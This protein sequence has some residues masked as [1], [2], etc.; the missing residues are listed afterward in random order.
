MAKG[1][2]GTTYSTLNDPRFPVRSQCAAAL[3]PLHFSCSSALWAARVVRV[4]LAFACEAV[5]CIVQC[6]VCSCVCLVCLHAGRRVLQ[7]LLS[8]H[9]AAV[10]RCGLRGL[11][12]WPFALAVRG[13]SCLWPTRLAQPSPRLTAPSTLLPLTSLSLPH[14]CLAPLPLTGWPTGSQATE[15]G[16]IGAKNYTNPDCFC[17]QNTR[18]FLI[19]VPAILI[20]SLDSCPTHGGS[21]FFVCFRHLRSDPHRTVEGPEAGHH[22]RVSLPFATSAR[23]ALLRIAA[24]TPH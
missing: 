16:C 24:A 15:G 14:L 7:S 2:F 13:R 10:P 19:S 5:G 8:L 9:P 17:Q 1:S 18:D 23:P 11:F 4:S 22:V 21:R 6:C 3:L 20:G 12:L